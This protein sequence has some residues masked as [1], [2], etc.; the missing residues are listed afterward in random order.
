MVPDPKGKP[1]QTRW[2]T[3]EQRGGR[4]LV[5]FSPLSG[6]THQIRA[7]AASGL[8][9]AVVGEPVY[10]RGGAAMLRQARRLDLPSGDG[11]TTVTV[12]VPLTDSS[13]SA[14]FSPETPDADCDQP[15]AVR[16][17]CGVGWAV[18][19]P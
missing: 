9:A 3:I 12:P 8:G 11:R 13:R 10:G 4:A 16:A 7:H 17:E 15:H 1:A 5:E 19:N 2:R 6:R 14:G 18:P